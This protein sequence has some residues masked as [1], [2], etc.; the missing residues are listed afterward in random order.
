MIH[1]STFDACTTVYPNVTVYTLEEK[2]MNNLPSETDQNKTD[3]FLKQ[4]TYF[5]MLVIKGKMS[6]L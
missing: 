2:Q 5:C 6:I 3:I 1:F 4:T